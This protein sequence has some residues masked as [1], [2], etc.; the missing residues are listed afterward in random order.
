MKVYSFLPPQGQTYNSFN[1]DAKAFFTYL[2]QNQGFPES[3]QNLI[4]ALI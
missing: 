1:A 2:T 3:S 4:G